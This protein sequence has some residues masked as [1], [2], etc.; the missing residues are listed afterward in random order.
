MVPS[1]SL[2]AI[3][4][5]LFGWLR[6]VAWPLWLARGLDHDSGARFRG[7]HEHLSHGTYHCSADFRRLR[8]VTRQI[9]VFSEAVVQGMEQAAVAVQNGIDY[10]RRY[11]LHPSGGYCW[12][13]D[14][15][16]RVIDARRDLYDHAFVLL[17]L[18]SAMRACPA[19]RLKAEALAL[20]A[21]LQRVLRHPVAGYHES[22][23]HALPRR[24]NPHMHLLE[25]YLA[26]A[27]SFGDDP[28][29][30]RADEI[31]RL[32]LDHLWLPGA[33]LLPEYFDEELRPLQREEAGFVVEPGHHAEWVWL[34]SWHA[35]S[36]A[37]AGRAPVPGMQDALRGLMRFVD[38]YGKDPV[39]GALF[40]EVMG[41]GTV[42]SRSQRLWPQTEWLKA[43]IL[44]PDP[45]EARIGEAYRVLES[46]LTPAG[47]W[48]ERRLANGAWGNDPVPASSLYHLTSAITVAH[49][50]MM[51]S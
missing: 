49:R 11:A 44:R 6:D 43:E 32:F 27:E 13:F 28:F 14:L 21:Y 51:A 23:P 45:T 18:S 34:L 39:T 50:A 3:D 10:L 8:V 20:D 2:R 25:A 33:G 47:L 1:S 12:R 15:D 38:L 29:L 30:D 17:A 16:G 48:R 5:R 41:D 42:R 9:Y 24:Q 19:D 7:F 35:R 22:L 46:Y 40:D 31:A 36:R 4:D 37:R 26:A